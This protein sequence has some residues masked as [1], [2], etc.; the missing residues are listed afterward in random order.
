MTMIC[1]TRG[2]Q[3]LKDMIK[4][5]VVHVIDDDKSFRLSLDGLLRSVGMQTRLY[6]SVPEFL[7]APR[8][9]TPGCLLLDVRLPGM[10]GLDFQAQLSALNI[11]LPVILMTGHADVPMSVKG[12]KAGAID[13]L[14]KPFRDQD[15]LDAI[16]TAV[17]RDRQRQVLE[18]E[19]ANL[20]ERY[21]LLSPREK[22]VMLLVT[23]GKMNKQAAGELHLSE[24]TV[25]I[26]RGAAMR[27]MGARTLTDLVRMVEALKLTY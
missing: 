10:S 14:T 25:K 5:A 20:R 27:K 2:D 16:A 26:H 13:F 12:M 7:S 17:E 22:E 4:T 8:P 19:A 23:S 9:N 24:I 15:V 18:G 3:G 1:S 11:N 6:G 21:A